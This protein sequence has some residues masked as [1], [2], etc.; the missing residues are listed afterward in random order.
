MKVL[1]V[2]DFASVQQTISSCRYDPAWVT[3]TVTS[4]RIVASECQHGIALPVKEECDGKE[5]CVLGGTT[6][7]W[8]SHYAGKCKVAEGARLVVQ[9]QCL[10]N[11]TVQRGVVLMSVN[12]HAKPSGQ[13]DDRIAASFI[14][15]GEPASDAGW[16][17]FQTSGMEDNRDGAGWGFSLMRNAPDGRVQVT[18]GAQPAC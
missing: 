8:A 12:G 10:A 11:S 3:A 5:S 1:A 9:A 18:M 4:Y 16:D 6:A 13:D 7:A 15:N 14:L 17:V 2:G